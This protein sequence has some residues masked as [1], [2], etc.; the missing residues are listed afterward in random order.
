MYICACVRMCVVKMPHTMPHTYSLT[1]TVAFAIRLHC[2]LICFEINAKLIYTTHRQF[3]QPFAPTAKAVSH[4]PTHLHTH[5]H[6]QSLIHSCKHAVKRTKFL[7]V[8]FFIHWG[9]MSDWGPDPPF[10]WSWTWRGS[11]KILIVQ[12]TNK[13]A[14]NWSQTGRETGHMSGTAP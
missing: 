13:L 11:C 12:P 4:S 10:L 8:S 9:S 5:T 2:W 3:I 14:N 1:L 7:F 6:T